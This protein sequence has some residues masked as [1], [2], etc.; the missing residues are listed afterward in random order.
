MNRA[1]F[2]DRD[3]VINS[4]TGLYYVYKKDDFRLNPGVIECLRELASRGYLLLIIS[5]QG[6]IARG[7]YTKN[8][9]LAIHLFLKDECR[10][11]GVEITEIYFCPH[12][13]DIEKCICRKPGTLMLEKS[14]ARFA[15]DKEHSYFVGD[16]ETDIIAANNAGIQ[17]ILVK[18]NGNLL[19]CL[20]FI[21]D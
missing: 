2:F 13:V 14:I 17:P 3:G 5:N 15:I 9:V 10:K 6:G 1:V 19:E 18:A 11:S 12:H 16:R 4:D 20:K 21:A 7:L 8:D